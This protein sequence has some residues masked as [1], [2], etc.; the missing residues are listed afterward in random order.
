[1]KMIVAK[2]LTIA[3][4]VG[5]LAAFST[6]VSAANLT[7][8]SAENFGDLDGSASDDDGSAN[9]TLTVNGNLLIDTGGSINCN[10]SAPLPANSGACNIRIVVGGNM[11]IKAGGA[12]FAENRISGGSGGSIE[13]ITVAGNLDLRGPSGGQPGAIISSSRTTTGGSGDGGDIT[14]NVAGTINLE[15]GSFVSA[16]NAGGGHAGTIQMTAEGKIN[17]DALVSAGPSRTLLATK[18][19]PGFVLAGGNT[20]QRGGKITIV[21]HSTAAP[22]IYVSTAGVIV[23]Q[24]QDPSSDRIRLEGC[25]IQVYGL[26]A[27]VAVKAHGSPGNK[28]EIILL[29]GLDIIVDG[30]DLGKDPSVNPNQGR[31]RADYVVGENPNNL[32]GEIDLFA[33]NGDITVSGPTSGTTY[34][35]TSNGGSATNQKGGSINARALQG[36]L[37]VG[38]L[39]LQATGGT[40]LGVPPGAVGGAIDLQANGT[41]NLDTARLDATGDYNETGGYGSGGDISV[42]STSANL[43]WKNG[44]GDVR[45]TGTDN[46]GVVLPAA[47]RGVI[48]LTHCTGIDTTGTSFPNNGLPATTPTTVAAC[49]ASPVLPLGFTCPSCVGCPCCDQC[50]Q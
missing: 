37:F 10:D 18:L 30:R 44:V 32:L 23:S 3:L 35:V 33:C 13:A 27:S 34:V 42:Q 47:N 2:F 29:S 40:S 1:M 20:T 31:L 19:G 25:G 45:P 36:R 22:G 8:N 14:I 50:I 41:A 5:Q 21:S 12:V 11:E 38:G 7:I 39:A 16:D 4:L 46:V 17:I 48:T 49:V 43:S 15:T 6:R 9:G 24:G 26:V 28:P